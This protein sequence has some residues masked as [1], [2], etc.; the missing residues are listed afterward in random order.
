MLDETE[1]R[2]RCQV[3][4]DEG[5]QVVTDT[6][7]LALS[8]FSLLVHRHFN[9]EP[10]LVDEV[11]VLKGKDGRQAFID[12]DLLKNPI[13]NFLERLMPKYD[14]PRFYNQIKELVFTWHN[15][16]HNYLALKSENAV[17]SARSIDV[18]HVY[19]HPKVADLKR[20]VMAHI[21]SL[22]DAAIEFEDIML[23]LIHI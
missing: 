14:D 1:R 16:C 12:D 5:Q 7:S 17:V 22:G 3:T 10:Y 11:V 23:S 20:R 4:D 18:L 19:Q 13:D 6:W 9:E 21:T 2:V 8:W 15:Q